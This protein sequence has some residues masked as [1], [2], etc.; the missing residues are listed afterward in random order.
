MERNV[1]VFLVSDSTG[2]TV[3]NISR[4]V[5]AHFD[6]LDVEEHLWSMVRSKK[7]IDK[8]EKMMSDKDSIVMFTFSNEELQNYLLNTCTAHNILAIPVLS[9]VVSILSTY[10]KQKPIY[11]SGRQHKMNE[12]YFSKISAINYALEHD[13]GQAY[14]NLK[15]AEIILIGPSRTSKS[16]TS[17]YLA[18]RGYK[19]ANIPFINGQEL[20]QILFELKDKL[21]VGLIINCERLIELRKNRL[22]NLKENS[23]SN[24]TDYEQVTQEIMAARK[25]YQKYNWPV[26]DVTRKS[27]EETCANIIQFY[28]QQERT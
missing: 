23:N 14:H 6:N 21:I 16:P 17:I 1:K 27:V 18:Y 2:E 22:L 4:S 26:I 5:F 19:V 8:L 20:P 9:Q 10:L 24:Y 13:D 7:Q 15:E 25:L 28:E 11:A 3:T 12:E